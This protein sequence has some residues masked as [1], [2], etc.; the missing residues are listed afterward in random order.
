MAWYSPEN[1]N[2]WTKCLPHHFGGCFARFSESVLRF[3]RSECHFS[4]LKTGTFGKSAHFQLLSNGWFCA[5]LLASLVF[6]RFLEQWN[7][8]QDWRSGEPTKSVEAKLYG[9]ESKLVMLL[10]DL[11]LSVPPLCQLPANARQLW[12]VVK[13]GSDRD[14]TRATNVTKWARCLHCQL[15]WLQ[16]QLHPSPPYKSANL[17]ISKL[18]ILPKPVT[19]FSTGSRASEDR[20]EFGFSRSLGLRDF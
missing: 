14:A 16:M 7:D 12:F 15:A 4:H 6:Q 2:A 13:E 9:F 18:S 20:Q 10:C 3:G 8:G 5:S 11:S 1:G 19:I 17:L